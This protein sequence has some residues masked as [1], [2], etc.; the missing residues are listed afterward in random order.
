MM[1]TTYLKKISLVVI[2]FTSVAVHAMSTAEICKWRGAIFGAIAKE[3]DGGV[4]QRNVVEKLHKQF[5]KQG[6]KRST[7]NDYAS[8][9]YSARD[10]SPE[11]LIKFGEVSCRQEL[12]G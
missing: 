5:G 11:T 9:I 2:L 12:G 1:T 8:A 4:P 7:I 3:R 10:L 6:V